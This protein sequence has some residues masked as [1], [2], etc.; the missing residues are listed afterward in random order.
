MKLRDNSVDW[1]IGYGLG[2]ATRGKAAQQSLLVLL[3]Q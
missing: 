2:P 3:C 1:D